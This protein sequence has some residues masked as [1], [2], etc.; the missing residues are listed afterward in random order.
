[1]S[2]NAPIV[3]L[4]SASIHVSDTATAFFIITRGEKLAHIEMRADPVDTHV[5]RLVW[6][7]RNEVIGRVDQD[8]SGAAKVTPQG[9]HWSPMKSVGQSFASPE[10]A[11]REIQL[12]FER[13]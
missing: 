4:P 13:R 2:I 9:P 8:N 6:V 3:A 12:Y 7:E 11:L 5:W 10:S 1:M